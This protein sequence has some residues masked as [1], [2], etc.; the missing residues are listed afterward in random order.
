[1][2]HHWLKHLPCLASVGLLAACTAPV[3]PAM[4]IA[5]QAV[6]GLSYITTGKSGADHALSAAMSEDCALHRI[7][8]AGAVCQEIARPPVQTASLGGDPRAPEN[9]PEITDPSAEFL[10]LVSDG[11]NGRQN[12]AAAKEAT[13]LAALAPQGLSV[14]ADWQIPAAP[15]TFVVAATYRLRGEG[16]KAA[17]RIFD[18][19]GQPHLR[20]K[21]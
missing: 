2:R 1:M 14:P 21:V 17:L 8:T 4:M 9:E 11:G 10:Q 16:E 13:R 6:D 18:V 5:S 19:P 3:P 15:R 7:V 12:V 20:P